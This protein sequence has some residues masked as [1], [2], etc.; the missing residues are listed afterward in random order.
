[1]KNSILLILA[2]IVWFV[3]GFIWGVRSIQP[4]Q[5]PP[6]QPLTEWQVFTL[7]MIEVES[8]FD[9]LAVNK[10]PGARG[11]LQIMPIYISEVNRLQDSIFYT[12]TDAYNVKLSIDM[13]NVINAD[14]DIENTIKRHNPN[15]GNWYKN[16]VYKAMNKIRMIEK[17]RR[18][19]K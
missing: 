13:F 19:A 1:M 10:Q 9:S 16:R 2:C 18:I 15:A 6:E 8:E 7:A 14:R 4:E 12:H 5:H 17:I 3:V 11:V